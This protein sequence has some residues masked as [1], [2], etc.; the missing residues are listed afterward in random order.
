M[1]NLYLVL[2]LSKRLSTFL[3]LFGYMYYSIKKKKKTINI[4]CQSLAIRIPTQKRAT[5]IYYVCMQ[6]VSS[7]WT[8]VSAAEAAINWEAANS[9]AGPRTIVRLS[10]ALRKNLK[11]KRWLSL[12]SELW[13]SYSRQIGVRN[14][15]LFS[16]CCR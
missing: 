3:Y 1:I 4:P 5:Y 16:V 8:K 14:V 12:L 6:L 10:N 13:I 7:L 11:R 9:L 15:K 2:C